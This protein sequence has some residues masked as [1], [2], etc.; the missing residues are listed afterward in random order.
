[1]KKSKEPSLV[2]SF[3]ESF[4]NPT[5]IL[6]SVVVGV[7]AVRFLLDGVTLTFFGQTFTLAPT[8]PL[9]Y[10]AILTPVLGAHSFI[11]AKAKIPH[12]K[13]DENDGQ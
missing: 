13:V 6:S 12:K 7:C 8:D 2:E 10:G 11:R 1:M 3:R 9:S 5:F 4:E